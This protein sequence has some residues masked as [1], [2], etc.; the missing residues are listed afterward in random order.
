MVVAPPIG[1][2]THYGQQISPD[3]TSGSNTL[4]NNNQNFHTKQLAANKQRPDISSMPEQPTIDIFNQRNSVVSPNSFNLNG[5]QETHSSIRGGGGG[6]SG[7]G[8][9]STNAQSYFERLS[10]I[11]LLFLISSLMFLVLLALGLVGGYYCF[12]RQVS[13]NKQNRASA[14]LRRKHRYLNTLDHRHNHGATLISPPTILQPQSSHKYNLNSQHSQLRFT[15]PN[16]NSS[17]HQTSHSHH[18]HPPHHHSHYQLPQSHRHYQQHNSTASPSPD[19]DLSGQNLLDS[20]TG[21]LRFNGSYATPENYHH[22]VPQYSRGANNQLSSRASGYHN[23]HYTSSSRSRQIPSNV[24]DPME[25]AT[26]VGGILIKQPPVVG[27]R[28]TNAQNYGYSCAPGQAQDTVISGRQQRHLSPKKIVQYPSNKSHKWPPNFS[29]TSQAQPHHDGPLL[30]LSSSGLHQRDVIGDTEVEYSNAPRSVATRSLRFKDLNGSRVASTGASLMPTKYAFVNKARAKLATGGHRVVSGK[31]Q[32]GGDGYSAAGGESH[33]QLWRA[34]SLS[35]VSKDEMAR[36][37][38]QQQHKVAASGLVM[39]L[40][41]T[42]SRHEHSGGRNNYR[43]RQVAGPGSSF[44]GSQSILSEERARFEDSRYSSR[45]AGKGLL[46]KDAA[47]TVDSTATTTDDESFINDIEEG[48]CERNNNVGELLMHEKPMSSIILKSIEDAYIT[49]FTEIYEQEY[50]KRDSTRPLALNEWRAMQPRA[51]IN[52]VPRKGG[53]IN[54]EIVKQRERDNDEFESSEVAGGKLV[55]TQTTSD[56]DDEEQKYQSA[57]A[58]NLRS[59]TELDVN[60]AKSLPTLAS[61][62]PVGSPLKPAAS[63]DR[64]TGADDELGVVGESSRKQRSN[65]VPEVRDG[66]GQME[67]S[68]SGRGEYS[69]N[70]KVSATKKVATASLVAGSNL[71]T[72]KQNR[73]ES[74]DLILSPDYDYNRLE[75][76]P[77]DEASKSSHNSVSYV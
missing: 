76:E 32:A 12:R 16:P 30:S 72:N 44:G 20:K 51:K 67:K 29:D 6:G 18:L 54:N 55:S 42:L 45:V 15:N 47:T 60:F 21:S 77:P 2:Q 75:F 49:N 26:T 64:L 27:R 36:A 14:I 11:E 39:P 22:Q 73:P 41:G 74:P 40:G 58:T 23:H 4:F 25:S 59:L 69:N 9:A 35:A 17:Q 43:R 68:S 46:M 19:S 50:M 38:W 63:V 1:Q 70:G 3:L 10:S 48:I 66:R 34:K 65:S 37:R 71:E 5:F 7:G 31:S 53:S 24:V 28:D 52:Q 62:T 57:G 56:E 33:S 13:Q 61:T 8:Q